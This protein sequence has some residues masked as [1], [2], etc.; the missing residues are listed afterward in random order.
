[1][2]LRLLLLVLAGLIILVVSSL[3]LYREREGFELFPNRTTLSARPGGYKALYLTLEELGYPPV[4]RWRKP[5]S[6]FTRPEDALVITSLPPGQ[7]ISGRDRDLVAEWVQDGGRLILIGHH[8]PVEHEYVHLPGTFDLEIVESMEMG[9]LLGPLP[10]AVSEVAPVQPTAYTRGVER[11][12]TGPSLRLRP[13]S[14]DHVVHLQDVHGDLCVSLRSG[15]GKV[16]AIADAD[17][18]SNQFIDRADNLR[19]VL[20]ILTQEMG[21]GTVWFD[22]YHHGFRETEGLLDYGGESRAGPVGL[23]LV[24]LAA[25]WL[26]ASTRRFGPVRPLPPSVRTETTEHADCLANLYA[27]AGARSYALREIYHRFK[28]EAARSAG[29]PAS[30]DAAQVAVNYARKFGYNAEALRRAMRRCEA[31]EEAGRLSGR[32]L[33]RLVRS[34]EAFAAGRRPA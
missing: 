20:N 12:E 11:A 25:V 27:A 32:E 24:V 33:V 4:G 9:P 31:A 16:I 19:L 22:E 18:A 3:L 10:E 1:M 7:T 15:R 26:L 17:L 8:F 14:P 6:D 29:L 23:Q 13:T 34:L 28:A 5:L 30:A 21:A 2:R